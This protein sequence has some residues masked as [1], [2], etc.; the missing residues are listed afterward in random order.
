VVFIYVALL[1][2]EEA[3]ALV[4]ISAH[5]VMKMRLSVIGTGGLA[6]SREGKLRASTRT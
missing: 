4:Y 1:A 3:Y 2:L 6:L 5:S